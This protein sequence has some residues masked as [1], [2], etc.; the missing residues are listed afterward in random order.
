VRIRELVLSSTR[1]ELGTGY[2]GVGLERRGADR[3]RGA[4]VDRRWRRSSVLIGFNTFISTPDVA[5]WN[6]EAYPHN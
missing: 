2:P 4:G 5:Q 1:Q 6:F 3:R